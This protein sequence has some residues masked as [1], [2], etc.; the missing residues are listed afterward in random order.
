MYRSLEHYLEKY[1]P[2]PQYPFIYIEVIS[3]VVVHK[4]LSRVKSVLLL[5]VKFRHMFLVQ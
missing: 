5:K 4:K 1:S 3:W 2:F